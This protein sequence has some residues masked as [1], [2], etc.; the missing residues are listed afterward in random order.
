MVTSVKGENVQFKGK[1]NIHFQAA[2]EI[3]T[4]C[5]GGLVGL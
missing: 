5:L 4:H 2:S 1:D 3:L